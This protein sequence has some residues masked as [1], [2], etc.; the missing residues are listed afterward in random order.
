MLTPGGPK[1]LEFNGRFGD[2]ETE[3]L[4]MRLRGDLVDILWRTAT[5]SLDE[6]EVSFDPR[7]AV[8]TVVCAAGYPGKPRTGDRIEGI[9]EAEALA[10]PG[11]QVVVFHAG[12]APDPS[13]SAGSVVTKGGRVLVVTALAED[14]RR[15]RDLSREAAARIRFDGAFFR[16]D[17]AERVLGRKTGTAGGPV[18]TV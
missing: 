16:R 3:P 4:L 15:A 1:V 18:A 9:A 14:L 17:L 6:A 11:E 8:G 10:G 7:A 13:G 12:T 5:G 2:P